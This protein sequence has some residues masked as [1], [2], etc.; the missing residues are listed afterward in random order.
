MTGIFARGKSDDGPTL[1]IAQWA[2]AALLL[3]Y[4]EAD[5]PAAALALDELFEEK[6]ALLNG[7]AKPRPDW[8]GSRDAPARRT[9]ESSADYRLAPCSTA[10]VASSRI[11]V[12]A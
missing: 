8:A 4:I 12:N 9:P 3:D 11:W 2:T 1:V 7:P 6:A 5:N 10:S